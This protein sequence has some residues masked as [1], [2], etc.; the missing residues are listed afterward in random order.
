MGEGECTGVC[1]V[2][3]LPCSPSALGLLCNALSVCA[4]VRYIKSG[5][6]K[7]ANLEITL[8]ACLCT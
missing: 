8:F 6:N 7:T 3:S 2:R 1:A 4:E 5:L